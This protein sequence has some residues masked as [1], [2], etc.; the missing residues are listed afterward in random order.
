LWRGFAAERDGVGIFVRQPLHAERDITILEECGLRVRRNEY[1]GEVPCIRVELGQNKDSLR[2]LFLFASINGMI[3]A[4]QIEDTFASFLH[5]SLQ[6]LPDVEHLDPG[7]ALL[8]KGLNL[9]GVFTV[10][11]C[12]GHGRDRPRIWL[13]TRWDLLWCQYA[14]AQV[15]P[16]ATRGSSWRLE[17]FTSGLVP[18]EEHPG[19]CLWNF[20]SD[21]FGWLR[22]SASL[23]AML[24]DGDGFAT[25]LTIQGLAQQL[26]HPTTALTLRNTKASLCDER[27]LEE[28]L[29]DQP[30]NFWDQ[31]YLWAE[32]RLRQ[33]GEIPTEQAIENFMQQV[34]AKRI[35]G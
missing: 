20:Q 14:L 7:I 25:F 11:S 34:Y 4:P 19:N 27:A 23:D 24:P 17:D 33:R 5:M 1:S 18:E 26:T 35:L 2:Q 6:P 21:H 13:R 28:L 15:E 22:Y 31:Q 12:C 8:V 29:S 10:M 9:A 32:S 30:K 16:L 3:G